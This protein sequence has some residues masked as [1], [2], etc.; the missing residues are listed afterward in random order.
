[1]TQIVYLNSEIDE[2]ARRAALM[3]DGAIFVHSDLPSARAFAEFA[4]SL[5]ADLFR[6]H[7]P[8]L[9]HE[10]L[11]PDE[12]ADA[13][14][15]FKPRFIHHPESKLHVRAVLDD[16]G[17][18]PELTYADVP[19]L[20]TAF[21]S[22]SLDTGIAYAFQQHRDTWYAAPPSQINVWLPVWPVRA[23][24]SMVFFPDGFGQQVPNNSAEYNY[25]QANVW[26]GQIRTLSGGRDTRVHPAPDRPLAPE[27]ALCV[28]P[29]LGGLM[30]FA[31]DHLHASTPNTSGITR[32][33]IDFR[34]VDVRDV[35]SRRG[36]PVRDV[37]CQGTAM[38]DFH[39]VGDQAPMD[40]SLVALYD[41][42]GADE[43]GVT[44]FHPTSS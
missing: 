20:R 6:P 10:V 1:M 38:R 16:L 21:P 35:E 23:D 11:G 44:V 9:I 33:S 34:F 22:G 13:L 5:I 40:D 31:G 12:L 30:M 7:D 29:P 27:R 2:A 14:V 15:E 26:R 25:Y 43:G 28:L 8:L 36:A 4:R 24:N 32:Y 17:C 19:K 18:P 42:A 39:R 3:G 41:T 37:A